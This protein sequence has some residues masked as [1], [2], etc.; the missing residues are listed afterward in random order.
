MMVVSL[1]TTEG[2]DGAGEGFLSCVD[3]QVSLES[4]G[5]GELFLAVT[6]TMLRRLNSMKMNVQEQ[7]LVVTL[8][9]QGKKCKEIIEV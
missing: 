3:Q 4:T 6:T 9:I 5:E 7:V 2:T 1:G 8:R